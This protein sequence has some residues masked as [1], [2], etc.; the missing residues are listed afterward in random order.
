MLEAF[1]PTNAALYYDITMNPAVALFFGWVCYASH[2][3]RLNM[4]L[5]ED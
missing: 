4:M 2:S 1:L 3:Y 5:T